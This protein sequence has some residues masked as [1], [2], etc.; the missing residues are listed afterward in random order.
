MTAETQ[1]TK[2]LIIGS[3]PAGLTAAVYA[4]RAGLDVIVV[5]GPQPGGQ[6][7]T[8]SGVDNFPGFEKG[9]DGLELMDK[10]REQ[11]ER[12]GAKIVSDIIF[13]V[14]FSVRP[15]V[16]EGDM[17]T[18]YVADAVIVATGASP[19][20]AGILNEEKFTGYGVSYCATC[21]GFFYKGKDVC[22]VGGGAAA[23]EEALYLSAIASKVYLINKNDTLRGE[24]F[25]S[26]K[27]M[28]T[29]NIIKCFNCEVSEF[30]GTDNPLSLEQAK[31]QYADGHIDLLNIKAA[32]IAVGNKPNT[33]IFKKWLDCDENGYIKTKADSTATKIKGVFSAG[34]VKNPFYRQAV[35]AASSGCLAALEAEHFL[36][37]EENV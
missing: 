3:G 19:K 23:L 35:T 33:D 16:C 6:L 24:Q 26:D 1:K 21:D 29:E 2:I 4:V 17:G 34:D 31:I 7:T 30:I 10:M 8:T 32:F 5:A 14:D 9:I 27:V 22:V 28:K 36:S 18:K 15:F 11:A 12:A 13:D 20:R 25:V 37:M